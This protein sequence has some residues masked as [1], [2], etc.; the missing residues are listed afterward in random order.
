MSGG[1]FHFRSLSLV[2]V[3]YGREQKQDT[4]PTVGAEKPKAAAK[5]AKLIDN[6]GEDRVP[7]SGQFYRLT[8]IFFCIL[9]FF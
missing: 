5:I 8:D 6:A 2:H 1:A 4:D 3:I 9:Q 7:A